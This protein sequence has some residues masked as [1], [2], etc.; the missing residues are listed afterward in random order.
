M[1]LRKYKTVRALLADKKRWIR[2]NY[3]VNNRNR[4]VKVEDDT[5]CRFC[6]SGAIRR[7]YGE[8]T[9]AAVEA[10]GQ[11][12]LA[13]GLGSIVAFNDSS[14]HKQVLAAVRKAKI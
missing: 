2:G 14:T 10:R 6:L 9:I 13:C 12:M 7:V 11:I 1:K 5:A 3:A 8:D 4:V